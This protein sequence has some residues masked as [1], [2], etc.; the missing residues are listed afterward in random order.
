[1]QDFSIIEGGNFESAQFQPYSICSA[2]N[3]KWN[4]RTECTFCVLVVVVFG[5]KIFL[6]YILSYNMSE[7]ETYRGT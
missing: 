1:M 7:K 2:I 3:I 5:Q 6:T 4:S